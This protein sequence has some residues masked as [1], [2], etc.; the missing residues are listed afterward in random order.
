MYLHIHKRG[1]KGFGASCCN[2]ISQKLRGG[3]G[4]NETDRQ[5]IRQI[6]AAEIE[7]RVGRADPVWSAASSKTGP[8]RGHLLSP[9]PEARR[10]GDPVRERTGSPSICSPSRHL[11][12]Q[13]SGAGAARQ[14]LAALLAPS[15]TLRASLP[16]LPAL[17]W[18]QRA[19]GHRGTR[20]SAGKG[21][22]SAL[23]RCCAG[24]GAARSRPIPPGQQAPL[25]PRC[26][27][28]GLQILFPVVR[29]GK[30]AAR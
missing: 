2:H 23:S 29:A 13:R 3:Q 8:S 17:P 7:T 4:T 25:L 1:T 16:P 9:D 11:G 26:P 14:L 10:S 21:S 12:G 19:R 15:F 24:I 5:E 30:K 27:R 20:G 22:C 28:T 18:P 6:R